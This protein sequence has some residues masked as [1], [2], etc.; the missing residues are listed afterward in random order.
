MRHS[1]SSAVPKGSP[2]TPIRL[3]IA[4]VRLRALWGTMCPN[5]GS[6]SILCTAAR[7]SAPGFLPDLIPVDAQEV[8]GSPT[9]PTNP[10]G[11]GDLELIIKQ[12]GALGL[13]DKVPG[14]AQ[15]GEFRT[16]GSSITLPYCWFSPIDT[17]DNPSLC[18]VDSY[19]LS[20]DRVRFRSHTYNRP[21]LVPVAKAL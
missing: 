6:I 7:P 8:P 9:V 11:N 13:D 3:G 17:W 19:D 21:D 10:E 16:V 20:G 12:A 2:G 5:P 18:A 1:S 14:F 15:I 4:S